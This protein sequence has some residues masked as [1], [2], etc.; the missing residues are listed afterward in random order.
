LRGLTREEL[1]K[2]REES[3]N[4]HYKREEEKFKEAADLKIKMDKHT[5]D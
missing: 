3:L 4:R 5:V 2:R 1:I